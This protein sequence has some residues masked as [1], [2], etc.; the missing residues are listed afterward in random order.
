MVPA[1]RRRGVS[2]VSDDMV[3]TQNIED[4]EPNATAPELIHRYVEL[5]G[6]GIIKV[7][8]L[9]SDGTLRTMKRLD[10]VVNLTRR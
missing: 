4:R 6:V 9:F 8:T 7:A 2:L 10:L 3:R 1:L 5:R